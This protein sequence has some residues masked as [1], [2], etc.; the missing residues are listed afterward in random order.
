MLVLVEVRVRPSR[1]PS[2]A[3]LVAGD[4]PA[5]VSAGSRGSHRTL[6]TQRRR[7]HRQ[8]QT[9]AGRVSVARLLGHAGNGEAA[10][11]ARTALWVSAVG[12]A[13]DAERDRCLSGLGRPGVRG[14]SME[15]ATNSWKSILRHDTTS[16]YDGRRDREGQGRA[17]DLGLASVT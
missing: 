6:D 3:A 4:R 9:H 13:A 16:A 8:T 12:A 14:S 5:S 7:T 10:D 11:G 2:A 15:V 17:A 1:P